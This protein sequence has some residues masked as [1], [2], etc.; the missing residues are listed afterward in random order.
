MTLESKAIS[1]LN[2]KHEIFFLRKYKVSRQKQSILKLK[3]YEVS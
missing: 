2:S 1:S 3:K